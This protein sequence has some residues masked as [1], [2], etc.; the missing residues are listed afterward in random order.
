M[1]TFWD[2]LTVSLFMALAITYLNRSIGEMVPGDRIAHYLAPAAL[3]A[4]ANW[5]GNNDRHNLATLAVIVAAAI[6]FC[7]IKPFKGS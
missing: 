2:W 4:S 1:V 7:V 3:L 5:L 6:Y